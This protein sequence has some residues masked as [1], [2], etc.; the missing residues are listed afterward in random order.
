MQLVLIP[1][2]KMRVFERVWL[3]TVPEGSKRGHRPQA[4]TEKLFQLKSYRIQ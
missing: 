3:I 1:V 2:V 4:E